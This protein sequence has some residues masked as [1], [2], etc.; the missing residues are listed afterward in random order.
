MIPQTF[1]EEVQARTDIVELIS[2][3][4]PLKRS[5][6]N[7][8]AL[9]PF[10]NEKTPSFFISPQKQIF[11]CF[12]CGEGGGVVQFILLI[13]KVSFVEAIEILAHRLGLNIPYQ[14]RDNRGKALL[15][16]IVNEAS[17][18][19]HNNLLGNKNL[20]AILEYL[21]RRGI[22]R[23]V[24][25]HFRIGFAIGN[26]TLFDYL[27]KKKFTIEA[28]EKASLVIPSKQG[29]RDL[30]WERI[31]FPIFDVRGRVVG[32]GGRIVKEKEGI[33]KYINSLENSLYSKREHL[34]GLNFSKEDIL[35][36][37][38]AIVVEGYLDMVVPFT[39]GI[40][41]IVASLGTA[42][43]LEQI[44][45]IKRYTSD[46]V[47]VFDSDKAGQGATLRALDILLE[48]DL[49]VKIVKLPK[50]Y[51][52][53][54]LVRE[55]GK[56]FF[57]QLLNKKDDFLDYKIGILANTYD[58]E[59]IEGKTKISHEILS[60][61]DKLRS[62]IEKYGY[63]KKLS[64]ILK[65]KE[66]ILIAEY[67]KMF[68][69]D[70][71]SKEKKDFNDRERELQP[72]TEKVILKFMLLYKQAFSLIRKNLTE[73]DFASP[74]IRKAVSYI[75]KNFSGEEFPRNFLGI[76]EDKDVSRFISALLM[77][78]SIP[79][80]KETFKKSV[81]KLKKR[82]I[83]NLR[84]KLREEIKDAELKG[85]EDRR[86]ELI[87]KFYKINSEARNG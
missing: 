11:H 4:I 19:F 40:R 69:K 55:K 73:D 27:R 16:E 44:R 65:I 26:N 20:T 72:I 60:T 28:M 78:D 37:R 46:I 51:D 48:N 31:I 56:D 63:I 22:D 76:I 66:E 8:R 24:I 17:L 74:L 83:K 23:Q 68:Y 18:F 33:P 87:N 59:S 3:Y 32:F 81:I 67:K 85:N 84:D 5:G 12:G 41:N 47:L 79:L 1:I 21:D 50:G 42:L 70:N 54:S 53:D 25:K 35:K 64:Q 43:T 9:C 29:W 10:H 71:I 30:F 75:F 58:I 86:R 82:R 39:R 77:D 14:R 62:E 36:N 15:Y 6:R 52:P 61:I 2:H 7:F 49:K 34:Y 45:L 38:E 80:D 57:L 13:E